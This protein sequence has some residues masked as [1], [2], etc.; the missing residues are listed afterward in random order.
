LTLGGLFIT[1]SAVVTP[2][3]DILHF[4]TTTPGDRLPNLLLGITLLKYSLVTF[5]VFLI[6]LG[7]LPIW[8]PAT[9]T[10]QLPL[11]PRHNSL[12][13]AIISI[14]CTAAVLRLYALDSGLWHDEI[15]TYVK[16]ARLPLGEIVS[17]YWNQNQH[18]LYT[19]LAH[20]S[21]VIFGDTAWSLRLP[22]ALF[23]VASIWAL[24][25]FGRQVSTDRETFLA[26]ALV[27]LS[28][29]HVWFSQNARGYIGLL[30]WTLLASWLF[31]RGLREA[32]PDLWLFYGIAAALGVYTNMAM[33]FVIMGHFVIYLWQIWTRGGDWPCRWIGFLLGFCFAGFLTLLLHALVLPQMLVGGIGEESTV[34][35]WKQPLWA[36]LEFMA[37]I[38]IGFAGM[39]AAVGA[40]LVFGIGLWSFVQ[41]E[42]SVVQLMILPALACAAAVVGLG[43]HLWPRLFF[44]TFGFAALIVVRGAIVLGQKAGHLLKIS[45]IGACRLG[46]AFAT[47]LILV[48]AFSLPH[49]YLPKQNFSA[50]LKFI[51]ASKEPGDT[52]AMVGLVTFTYKNFYVRDWR[53]VKTVEE[54]NSIR[55]H[56]KRTWLLYTFPTHVTAVYPEI[57]RSIKQ[58]FQIVKQFPGTVGDG[59]IFVSRAN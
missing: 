25:L 49:A 56:S 12:N 23:G 13:L 20:V 5:G 17:T 19:L 38:K 58:D 47:V 4:L 52:V 6:A 59:S 55:S 1:L 31:L 39:I 53:E 2:S 24:Y 44:F 42:P 37:A 7:R 8:Q 27:S 9:P 21:I 11:N 32:H 46:T 33:L 3:S 29:H 30:F 34:P 45:P 54:L 16:Y 14:L 22:A 26:C 15:V 10:E 40:L 36:I 41:T 48:S 18:F 28:Y 57:M 35:A 43:H 50:A 51:D